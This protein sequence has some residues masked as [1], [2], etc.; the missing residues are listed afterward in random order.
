[1]THA[2]RGMAEETAD[3]SHDTNRKSFIRAVW[4]VCGKMNF[5]PVYFAIPKMLMS[6]GLK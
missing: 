1:M 5:P 2:E 4:V 3:H 6:S